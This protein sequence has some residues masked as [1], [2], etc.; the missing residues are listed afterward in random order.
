M[1]VVHGQVGIILNFDIGDLVIVQIVLIDFL[2]DD[3]ESNIIL[4]LY[5]N[6][7]LIQDELQ[8]L[9]SVHGSIGLDLDLL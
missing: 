9:A 7:H 1:V 3:E 6:L 5:H 8:L 4:L 2:T